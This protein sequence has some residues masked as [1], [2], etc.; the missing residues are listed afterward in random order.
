[1]WQFFPSLSLLIF[2]VY[3][4]FHFGESEL[5]EI[6]L[7]VTAVS[8]YL[9]ALMLGAS[10]LVFIILTHIQ[11]SIAIII[12]IK[13]LEFVKLHEELLA[14]YAIPTALLAIFYLSI[15]A[16]STNK[17]SIYAL[18]TLLIVGAFTNLLIAFSIYFICQHSLNAW[19]HLQ[20]QL[21]VNSFGLYKK[22]LPHTIGAFL[23]LITCILLNIKE[24]NQV[25]TILPSFFIFLACISLPH[26]VFMHL[27]YKQE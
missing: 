9:K 25:K 18:V 10:I 2:I 21:K 3:S 8:T 23:I 14:K 7:T 20:H 5:Q 17:L 15:L 6:N 26:F 11:E 1:M 24:P 22:A 4:S 13:G 19:S 12:N 16:I 27:F